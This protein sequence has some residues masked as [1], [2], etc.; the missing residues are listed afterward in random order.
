MLV[1]PFP[2]LGALA[3][4]AWWPGVLG[5]SVYFA[6]KTWIL[7]VA[8]FFPKR[9]QRPALFSRRRPSGTFGQW[10]AVGVLL[11]VLMAAAIH[12]AYA[13]LGESWIDVQ[14][15]RE[16]LVQAGLDSKPRYLALAL[17]LALVNSLLEEW[18]WRRFV[19]QRCEDLAGAAMSILLSA[20]FFTVHHA[21]AFQFQLGTRTTMLA[22]AGV[23][24]AGCVW[25]WCYAR[26]RTLW[27]GYISHVIADVAGLWIGYRL[28][29][30]GTP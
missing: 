13:W 7:G 20:S 25:S 8:T 14:R 4:F 19:Q 29:F 12:G 21:V 2:T 18:V 16:V 26:F 5:Q 23:L 22:C 28:L 24:V 27:P 1:V 9:M 3:L 6:C 15:L 17:Y 11:G 30:E 10:L